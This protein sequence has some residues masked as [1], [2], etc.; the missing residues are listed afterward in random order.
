MMNIKDETATSLT[1]EEIINYIID[2]FADQIKQNY[3][4]VLEE[5]KSYYDNA[6][7]IKSESLMVL[8][9][10]FSTNCGV[11]SD[12]VKIITKEA[13]L[14]AIKVFNGTIIQNI[15]NYLVKDS[16]RIKSNGGML[17]QH[18]Y[19]E[20]DNLALVLD[21]TVIDLRDLVSNKNS[22][23]E[24]NEDV[25]RAESIDEKGNINTIAEFRKKNHLGEST[26]E[27]R[28][29]ES[30]SSKTLALFDELTADMY[31]I[32]N[33]YWTHFKKN[34]D[35]FVYIDSNDILFFRMGKAINYEELSVRERERFEPMKRI[36]ALANIWVSVRGN[37]VELVNSSG[38]KTDSE[39]YAFTDFFKLFE[40]KGIRVASDK[41]NQNQVKGIYGVYYKPGPILEY[42]LTSQKYPLGA[43]DKKII[44]Y[45]YFREREHKKIARY[46][47]QV[48]KIS[49]LT[50]PITRVFKIK[51]IIDNTDFPKGYSGV[52]TRDKFEN[53]LD[54]LKRDGIIEDWDY[55]D[56]VDE[57]KVGKKG[58]LN[59]YWSELRVV[60]IPPSSIVEENEFLNHSTRKLVK[61]EAEE[62]TEQ[63][64]L[65]LTASV[66][67]DVIDISDKEESTF[68]PT[69]ADQ[70][71][72]I[73]E[74][75]RVITKHDLTYREA[76]TEID[77]SHSTL[78][79][80]LEGTIK[81]SSSRVLKKMTDWLLS[82][83]K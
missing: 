35:G 9:E 73:A 12:R 27:L 43:I 34:E 7:A 59:N 8:Y 42:F 3:P 79:R 5:W 75:K 50:G 10:Y 25:Y 18:E 58:W 78:H 14:A 53:V 31:D 17:A 38:I 74:V 77:I 65:D 6:S 83:Q 64:A 47:S 19:K 2:G 30:L 52:Q 80:N 45:N 13:L 40:I 76:A 23:E 32:L 49:S 21:P 55:K 72:I 57:D 1:K 24:I 15:E 28:V 11:Y 26:Q 56:K 81:K 20:I 66:P 54:D 67:I 63:L 71:Q 36:L 46:L 4:D 70:E 62:G 69:N 16:E 22:F 61:I 44:M 60:I 41:K 39:E 51:T 33:Y 82:K 48:W 68:D 37:D 29:W